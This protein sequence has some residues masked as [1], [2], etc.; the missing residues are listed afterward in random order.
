[1][2]IA[3]I[4]TSPVVT[5]AMDDKLAEV[6]RL[7]QQAGFHHLLVLDGSTLVGVISDRDLLKAISP[8][9]D[10]ASETPRDLATLNKRA[11][12]I[13]SRRP[14]TVVKEQPVEDAVGLFC[15]HRIS[16]LPVIDS[17]GA[18]IGIVS[19]RDVLRAVENQ[20]RPTAATPS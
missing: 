2:I 19:W 15:Q 16:C 12:Q 5:V 14:I 13:M 18:A 6:R 11:H 10:S 17:K 3:D 1:M 8:Y 20:L 7:F 9:V 4:M